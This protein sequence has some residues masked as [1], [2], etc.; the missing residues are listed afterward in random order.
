MAMNTTTG[1]DYYLSLTPQVFN[2]IIK[3]YNKV[4]KERGQ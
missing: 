1:M 2:E 4:V 3:T